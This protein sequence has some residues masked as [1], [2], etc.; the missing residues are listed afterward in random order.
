MT[1]DEVFDKLQNTTDKMFNLIK[2][3]DEQ[4][5][6]LLHYVGGIVMPTQMNAIIERLEKIENE[7]DSKNN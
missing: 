1:E 7:S 2:I 4:I 6:F 3:K 5:K